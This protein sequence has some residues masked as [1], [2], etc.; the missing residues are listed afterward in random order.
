M[1]EHLDGAR[2][3]RSIKRA[4]DDY[5]G[6]VLGSRAHAPWLYVYAK[7]RGGFHEGW[8]PIDF[9]DMVVMRHVNRYYRHLSQ[10]KSFTRR[11]LQH[12]AIPDVAQLIRGH[13]YDL[14]MRP[15]AAKDAAG[16]IFAESPEVMVKDDGGSQSK[17]VHLFHH[18][19]FNAEQVARAHPNACLQARIHD[20][21]SLQSISGGRG[22][23][24]RV[25]TVRAHE[26][27]AHA[28]GGYLTLPSR[29][30]NHTEFQRSLFVAVDPQS[31]IT[32]GAYRDH[33]APDGR[34]RDTGIPLENHI[35]PGYHEAVRTCVA[36]HQRVP[37]LGVIG[38]DVMIDAAAKTWIIEWN[39]RV[40]NIFMIEAYTGP[41]FV[42]LGW[43]ALRWDAE[44]H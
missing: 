4:A 22:S 11:L 2:L 30:A 43:H 44:L 28:V 16:V 13:Y 29:G 41:S 17:H 37:H 12:P 39:T 31:G 18:T 1:F 36:L 9:F 19:T 20:H 8:I 35:I 26:R 24:L 23:K 25:M 40:P 15:I 6:D 27:P 34:H 33:S 38:W 14:Q 21:P 32:R 10:A 3:P 5:A 7:V 42:H